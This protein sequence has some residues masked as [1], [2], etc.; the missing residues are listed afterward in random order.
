MVER[1][2]PTFSFGPPFASNMGV[3]IN[4][5]KILCPVDFSPASENA[6]NY[7]IGLARSYKARL[8]LLH[9]V[10]PIIPSAHEYS[11]NV[12]DLMK[13]MEEESERLIE[14]LAE[15][16]QAAGVAAA[17]EVRIGNVHNEINRAIRVYKPDLVAMGTHG[18]RGFE[19]WF[20][21]STTERLLRH[22]PVPVLTISPSMK[23]RDTLRRILV[24]TDFSE[25]TPD[26]LNY[27][28]SIARK[29]Q[30]SL[31]LFH[32]LGEMRALTSATYRTSQIKRVKL[33]LLKTVPAK[34]K[35]WCTIQPRVEAGTPYDEILKI[36]G[37]EKVDLLV[38]NVHGKSMLDRA[39]LGSTAERVVRAAACP[40]LLIPPMRR[41]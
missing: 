12:G 2:L 27:A 41:D 21:G 28:L 14:K 26:A 19:R 15:K 10:S 16:A 24:T 7:A 20:L 31:T 17:T 36:I 29:N 13:S 34:A 25:G 6:V 18:R 38:M 35:D 22:S 23:S 39:L 37:K 9:V 32:V 4:I 11:L 8:K 5:R 1:I 30:A 40:V 33:D 3:M